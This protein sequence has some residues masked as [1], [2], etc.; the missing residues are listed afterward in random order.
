MSSYIHSSSW[1]LLSH[2]QFPVRE[3]DGQGAAFEHSTADDGSGHASLQ[4]PLQEAL[5]WA[6]PVDRVISG[7]G[8]ETQGLRR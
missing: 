5:E 2:R 7:P 4:F 3:V 6:G 8:D 1:I